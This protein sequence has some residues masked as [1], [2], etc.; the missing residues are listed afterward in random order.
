[1]SGIRIAQDPRNLR[2]SIDDIKRTMEKRLLDDAAADGAA[3]L[4]LR[5][6]RFVGR[7]PAAEGQI[8]EDAAD[9]MYRALLMSRNGRRDTAI[10]DPYFR[11]GVVE[12]ASAWLS[13][14][15]KYG[16]KHGTK[17]N[18]IRTIEKTLSMFNNFG[19]AARTAEEIGLSAR[20]HVMAARERVD[21]SGRR[22]L[23]EERRA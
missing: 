6:S 16:F 15:Q 2:L 23:G 14:S 1:V 21:I 8:Y 11:K 19:F 13:A 4:P 9:S 10:D 20:I 17:K 18:R 5:G 7:G 12:A 22:A 3:I